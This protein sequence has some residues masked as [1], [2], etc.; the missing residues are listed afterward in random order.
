MEYLCKRFHDAI[1][2]IFLNSHKFFFK[3]ERNN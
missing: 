2:I 3:E 1:Y